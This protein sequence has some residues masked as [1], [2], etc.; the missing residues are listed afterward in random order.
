MLVIVTILYHKKFI[1]KGHLSWVQHYE[2]SNL[3]EE[4]TPQVYHQYM[5]GYFVV[6]VFKIK[7]TV[8][9]CTLL[10]DA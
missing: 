10:K 2:D 3:T 7:N 8:L 4:I 5:F 1:V 6:I 9:R